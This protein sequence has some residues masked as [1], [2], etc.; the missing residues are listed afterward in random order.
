MQIR[1]RMKLQM[2]HLLG[3]VGRLNSFWRTIFL[4]V[5][6]GS[7]TGFLVYLIEKI[8]YRLLFL[9][10][11][12]TAF[13]NHFIVIAIPMIGVLLARFI[14]TAGKVDNAGGTEEVIKSYHEYRGKISLRNALYK[15]PAYIATLGFGGSAGLEG[16]ST[17]IGGVISSLVDRTFG[18]LRIPYEEQRVMLLAGAGAGLSAMFKAPF[19]GAIFVLQVPYRS[20]IAPNA[21]VPT[22]IASV[23][24]YIVM[25]SLAGTKPLFQ[26]A[27][28]AQFHFKDFLS[29]L[30]IGMVCGILTTVFIR[31]YRSTR[32]WFNSGKERIGVRHILGAFILGLTGYISTR[33]FGEAL[34]L[35]PG[36]IFIQH[37]L[38]LNTPVEMAIILFFLKAIAVIF[39]FSAGGIGGSFFPLLCLGAATGSVVAQ[40]ANLQPYDFGVVMGM[41]AFLAAG[42]KTPLA[43]VVFI[44]EATHSSGYLIPGLIGTV[45][46]Y[47]ISGST[48]ISTH[49]RDREDIHLSNRFHLPVR[50]AMIRNVVSVPENITLEEFRKHFVV[51]HLH[52]VYPVTRD[53][54]EGHRLIGIFSLYDLDRFPVEAWPKTPVSQAMIPNVVT[55]MAD[56]PILSAIAKMNDRDLEFLPVIDNERSRNLVGGLTRTD[57]FQGEWASLV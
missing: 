30:V 13:K 41:S 52:R 46:S 24:S 44:A 3:T 32:K 25:V 55:V 29:V 37:L 36:Y 31:L 20:D 45:V 53:T 16:A 40:I 15:I 23:S 12:N 5:L 51:R 56:E 9:T 21:L 19:T 6:I 39:T 33:A 26:L 35:G 27:A 11:Y 34:P 47:V 50:N 4:S 17:Y 8:V 43:A 18:W 42:Y 10:L 22:L 38:T 7:T 49:Q 28:K 1:R 48:S 57:V 54:P 2:R 14:L